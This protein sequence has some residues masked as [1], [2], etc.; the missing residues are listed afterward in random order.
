M[1][2][3][4]LS[5]SISFIIAFPAYSQSVPRIDNIL[6]PDFQGK[7]IYVGAVETIVT[8]PLI[9]SLTK[10]GEANPNAG[11]DLPRSVRS[12]GNYYAEIDYKG[13]VVSG[14]YFIPEAPEVATLFTGIRDGDYCKIID[15]NGNEFSSRCTANEFIS[16]L[17][18]WDEAGKMFECY[19]QAISSDLIEGS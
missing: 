10:K 12:R 14:R 13:N 8:P 15:N 11:V 19:I 9:A 16:E 17:V 18:Y 1:K 2:K 7:I 6:S 4:S 5:L 3:L